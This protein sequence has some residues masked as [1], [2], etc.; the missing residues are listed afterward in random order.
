MS[1]HVDFVQIEWMFVT[2]LLRSPSYPCWICIWKGK[3]LVTVLLVYWWGAWGGG[4][5][6]IIHAVGIP[7]LPASLSRA[8]LGI[9]WQSRGMAPPQP[10]HCPVFVLCLQCLLS[11]PSLLQI[12]LVALICALAGKMLQ[13]K[14]K[15][16]E[17]SA[18]W[19]VPA[20]DSGELLWF[21]WSFVNPFPSRRLGKYNRLHLWEVGNIESEFWEADRCLWLKAWVKCWVYFSSSSSC[22]LAMWADLIHISGYVRIT[23]GYSIS[24]FSPGWFSEPTGRCLRSCNHGHCKNISLWPSKNSVCYPSASFLGN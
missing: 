16:W 19:V 23:F 2:Y 24:H 12:L 10:R 14:R 8:V 11:T 17:L 15:L 6:R 9:W 18:Q 7:D 3:E 4:W 22:V 21:E 20:K 5:T 13:P 1:W